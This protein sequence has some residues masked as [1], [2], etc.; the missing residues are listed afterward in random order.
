MTPG[1]PQ[2]GAVSHMAEHVLR[3]LQAHRSHFSPD[4]RPRPLLVGV[5]GPQG[6]GKTFLTSHLRSQLISPPHELS[7]AVLSIDDLY[8]PHSELKALAEKHPHNRLLHGRGQPGT[9]DVPLGK[10][11]LEQLKRINDPSDESM[12]VELPAFDKSLFDGEGDRVP[13]GTRVAAPVD[14]VVLEGWCVGFY[15]VSEA[16]VEQRWEQPVKGLE[17]TFNMKAFVRKEDVLAVNE[18]LKEYVE[19]WRSLDAFVQIKGPSESPYTVI[20]KWRLQQ[21]HNMKAKNGG[22]GM[23]DE[24]VKTFVDRYIPGYVFFGDGVMQGSLVPGL[25]AQNEEVQSGET[26]RW[27]GSGLFITIGENRELLEVSSF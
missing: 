2:P 12:G 4:V 17:E 11:I 19:W 15:P 7:V 16:V 22:K 3:Q 5:Q 1:D 8:L 18:R 25:G 6:S 13:R 21:E 27:L 10:S 24:Q 26:P 23:T 9:H 14:V 20:Y